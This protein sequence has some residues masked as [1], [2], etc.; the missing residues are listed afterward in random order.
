MIN[1]ASVVAVDFSQSVR[2]IL[3]D[4]CFQCHG[5]D[6]QERQAD[7]RLD[8]E[9]G[10]I[11]AFADG[12]FDESEAWRTNQ[13]GR[14]RRADATAGVPASRFHTQQRKLLSEWDCTKEHRG[15]NTGHSQS[16]RGKRH[17]NSLRPHILSTVLTRDK[18][19][20]QGLEPAPR[21]AR[22]TLIRRLK[23]DLLGLPPTL[24][25]IDQFVNDTSP[26]AYEQ[27]VERLLASPQYGERMA[28][29]WLDGARYA[30]TNGYQNDFKR[31]MWPW[32][33]WVIEA[34][35]HNLPFDQFVVEQL[36]G[37][38]LSSPSLEQRIATGFNRNHRTVTEAGSI[39]AEW[40]VENVIDRVET[41]A[42]VFLGLT[43]GCARCHDHKYDPI[44]QREFYQFFSFFHNVK[45]KGVY[46][47]KRGNVAPLQPVLDAGEIALLNELR[48]ELTAAESKLRALREELPKHAA[49]WARADLP[50]PKTEV[51]QSTFRLKLA[52]GLAA[53][54]SDGSQLSPEVSTGT[55]GWESGILGQVAKLTGLHE[56]SYG[57]AISPDREQSFTFTFWIKPSKDGA[58]LDK[59]NPT[60]NARGID[61]YWKQPGR[62]E[63][64]LIHSW[65][66]DAIKVSTAEDG[67]V[68]PDRWSHVAL[69]YD[70]TGKAAGIVLRVD[71]RKMPLKTEVDT[72]KSSF[73]ND[74]PLRI[75]NP[76][77][78]FHAV[79]IAH[80]SPLLRARD[81]RCA[82]PSNHCRGFIPNSIYGLT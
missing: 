18:L 24:A 19:R 52:G 4:H 15:R 37:D 82:A 57:Q 43:M 36:A 30:D 33:D 16:R 65:A 71:G 62:L 17:R 59:I 64:H 25:E 69:S 5:P 61:I 28:A 40:L 26:D 68:P 21:A 75:G 44:S 66:G 1:M 74:S 8:T 45:E 35:S 39:P 11:Q 46:Q 13:L 6:E 51:P 12:N 56:L 48:T 81:Q 47:E 72:L 50:Q 80:R 23:F 55:V 7:L 58:V 41:T 70:G 10:V 77:A 42:T 2:P 73:A 63:M 79:R 67:T 14:F 76:S 34:F 38:L 9:A 27:L 31:S 3:S 53:T 78:R 20:E 32:R 49:T 54:L 60:E 29:E 22:E